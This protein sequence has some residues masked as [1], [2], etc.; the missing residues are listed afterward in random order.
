MSVIVPRARVSTVGFVLIILTVIGIGLGAVAIVTTSIGAQS[1]ELETLRR[2]A[3]QLTY[4]SAALKSQIESIGSSAS[5]AFRATD[6]G[7][8]P[9]PYPAFLLLATGEVVGAPTSVKGDELPLLRGM[10]VRQPPES[11]QPD[12]AASLPIDGAG[13]NPDAANVTVNDPAPAE[14][15]PASGVVAAPA[16]GTGAAAAGEG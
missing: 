14:T 2:E 6:L 1:R 3:T 16:Q 10:P 4:E 5:L 11:P 7:M 8:V 12:E 9:N 15:Q 13:G